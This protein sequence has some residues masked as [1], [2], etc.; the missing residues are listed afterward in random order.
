MVQ[1]QANVA[2]WAKL[3]GIWTRTMVYSAITLRACLVYK[4]CCW[5]G[6]RV[7]WLLVR[8]RQLVIYY[9]RNCSYR[10]KWLNTPTSQAA[11]NSTDCELKGT[12]M[13]REYLHSMLVTHA[14]FHC[15]PWKTVEVKLCNTDHPTN[16]STIWWLLY[17]HFL[18]CLQGC[19]NKMFHRS[20]CLTF[21]YKTY[22]LIQSIL[23]QH[24]LTLI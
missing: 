24:K 19:K 4:Y 10:W 3:L 23:K 22:K 1:M 12:K 14:T 11:H 6:R 18:L 8:W 17:T 7:K 2:T 13:W 5:W 21:N 9:C 20:A 16:Q 15:N